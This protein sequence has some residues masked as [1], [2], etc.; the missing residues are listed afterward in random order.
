MSE[1]RHYPSRPFAAVGVVVWKD[2]RLLVIKRAKPPR[3][4]QW[5]LVGGGVEL[6]ET[7]YEA[8][9]REVMEETGIAIA[10]FGIITAI[11]SITK[12]AD[13]KVEFHYS[14]IEVNA[15][16]VSGEARALDS[17]EE[18]AWLTL[19]EVEALPVWPQMKRVAQLAEAQY[20]AYIELPHSI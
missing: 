9:I 5:G 2:E 1:E 20:K 4:G 16:W 15:R 7:H 11:D 18:V 13:G 8:A 19:A 17:V 10:P 6:G 14:V 12:D 3:Q